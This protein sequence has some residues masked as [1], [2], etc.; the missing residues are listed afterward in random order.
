MAIRTLRPLRTA[1]L[2]LINIG[3]ARVTVRGSFKQIREGIGGSSRLRIFAFF[4]MAIL[5][6]DFGVSPA[7]VPA[8]IFVVI[9]GL[10]FFFRLFHQAIFVALHPFSF[11]K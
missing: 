7:K 4:F 2:M 10:H 1:H 5:A 6:S 8:R 3:V 9:E 11:W